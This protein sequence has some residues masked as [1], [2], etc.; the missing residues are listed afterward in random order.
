MTKPEIMEKQESNL[1]FIGHHPETQ[2]PICG[3]MTSQLD[4]QDA[5]FTARIV[6][7]ALEIQ[8]RHQALLL[9]VPAQVIDSIREGAQ[10]YVANV[11]GSEQSSEARVIGL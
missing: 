11:G 1:T 8:S 4:I 7:G 3:V 5:P 2:G 9:D 6:D 10:F